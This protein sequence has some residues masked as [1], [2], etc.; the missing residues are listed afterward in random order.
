[1]N[2][3]G[4]KKLSKPLDEP[5]SIT[6]KKNPYAPSAVMRKNILDT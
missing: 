5:T 3:R 6:K 1:M 4:H 2:Q